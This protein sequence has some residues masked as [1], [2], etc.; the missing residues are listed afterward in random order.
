MHEESRQKK[1]AGW[2]VPKIL[3]GQEDYVARVQEYMRVLCPGIAPCVSIVVSE[4]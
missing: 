2:D 3:W 4:T 1:I